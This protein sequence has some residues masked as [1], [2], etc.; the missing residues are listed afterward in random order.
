MKLPAGVRPCHLCLIF[1]FKMNME[2]IQNSHRVSVDKKNQIVIDNNF[3]NTV[4]N[5]VYGVLRSKEVGSWMSSD[6]IEEIAAAARFH[7]YVNVG[8]FDPYK[9]TADAWVKRA[10]H[11]FAITESKT[12]WN[13]MKKAVKMS[14]LSI[15]GDMNGKDPEQFKKVVDYTKDS[16]FSW[17][18]EG[19]GINLNEMRADY[20]F[21][22]EAEESA[23]LKRLEAL[24]HFLET[25]INDRE[26]KYLQMKQDDFTK[27]QMMAELNM[28]G[29]C[30][31]TFKSRFV[32]KVEKFMHSADY[33]GI[34]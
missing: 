17:A 9:G 29:G 21:V 23:S 28:N 1:N 27:E 15:L 12:L 3:I 34:E 26:K 19:L 4:T 6:Q 8:Q 20:S 33:W 16:T 24:T 7:I 2:K 10:A 31:D 25:G 13:K 18:A 5:T 30:F 14:Q 11:N 32:S 22:K